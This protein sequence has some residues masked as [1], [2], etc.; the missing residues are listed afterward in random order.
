MIKILLSS[1]LA[2]SLL[3]AITIDELVSKSI[4]KNIDLK[5]LEKSIQVANEQIKVSKNWKNPMLAFKTNEIMLDKPLS[6]QK[7]YGIELSQVIPVG[8]K[9][10]IEESIAKKDKNIQIFSLEDKKLELEA[11]IYEY[12]Y[13]ILILEKRYEILEFYQK[14]LDKLEDLYTSL[15]KYQKASLNEIL[16]TQIS[17]LDLKIELE[18]LK[19]SI[20]NAYL[21]L[22]Q[23]S[24]EK[25]DNISEKLSLKPISK[26]FIESDL[27]THPK[28]KALEENSLKY[29]E[30]AKLEEANK[31]SEVTLSVEYMQNKEQDFANISVAIPL[32]IYKTENLNKVKANLNS[33]ETNDRL[34]SL[35]HNLRLQNKIYLN[36]LNQSAKNYE[37]IRKEIIPLKE[38]IQKNLE[39]YNSFDLIKPQDNITNLNELLNYEI[40]ALEEALKYYEAY[41]QLIY[42]SNKGIK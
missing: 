4:E 18:N 32:P 27:L 23:I 22:E 19:T 3:S 10:D 39:N 33:N 7:E 12:S 41:S 37:L 16:N 30:I 31:F 29:K 38:K 17:K 5:G 34:K 42:F 15:Y 6:N 2:S 21:N 35:L 40:K 11:K 8:S 1:F 36:S 28:V 20:D 9:L 26:E 14:N 13:T 25:I 24:Y